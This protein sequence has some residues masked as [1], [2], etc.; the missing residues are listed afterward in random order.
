VDHRFYFQTALDPSH[1]QTIYTAGWTKNFDDP[2][3]LILETSNDGGANWTTFE[4]D[5]LDLFGGASSISAVIEGPD[6]AVY[7][8]LFRGGIMKVRWLVTTT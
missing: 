5:D 4:H 7:V 3:P 8:G 6:T 2:P 1:T